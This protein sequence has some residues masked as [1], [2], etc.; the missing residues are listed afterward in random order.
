MTDSNKVFIGV[1]VDSSGSMSSI[2]EDT[3]GGV[4][5]L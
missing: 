3:E 5:H 4:K 1:L 2:Q